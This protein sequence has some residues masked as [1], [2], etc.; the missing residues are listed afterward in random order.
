MA[1]VIAIKGAGSRN[2]NKLLSKTTIFSIFYRPYHSDTF[3]KM[4]VL[5]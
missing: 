3:V 2:I 1:V 4:K 5:F